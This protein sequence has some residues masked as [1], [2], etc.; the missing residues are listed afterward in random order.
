[1]KVDA[2]LRRA[3]VFIRQGARKPRMSHVS[4]LLAYISVMPATRQT[5]ALSFHLLALVSLVFCLAVC[6]RA[7]SV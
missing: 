5:H 4:F 7:E 6:R 2:L 1:M 3:S